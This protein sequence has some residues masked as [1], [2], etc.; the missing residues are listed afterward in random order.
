MHMYIFIYIYTYAHLI[1]VFRNRSFNTKHRPMSMMHYFIIIVKQD[2]ISSNA[3]TKLLACTDT[4]VSL[5]R[6]AVCTWNDYENCNNIC[7]HVARHDNEKA[8][9]CTQSIALT[10]VHTHLYM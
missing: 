9:G 2:S 5:I 8:K 10:H 1:H 7:M 6:R 3:S 4:L